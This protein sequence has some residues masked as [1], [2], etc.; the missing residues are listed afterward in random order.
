MALDAVGSTIYVNQQMANVASEQNTK[1]GRVEMQNFAAG[2]AVTQAE[3]E[4]IEVRPAEENEAIDED[5]EHQRQEDDEEQKRSPKKR[6]ND[7][8]TQENEPLYHLDIKV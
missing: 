3:K 6:V 7:K 8:E 5:R 4:V 1:I 2:M